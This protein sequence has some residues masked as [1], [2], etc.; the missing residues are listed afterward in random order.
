MEN[1]ALKYR[2]TDFEALVG[3]ETTVQA[4]NAY[5]DLS[6][7]KGHLLHQV[8]LF[9]GERGTGKTTSARILSKALNCSLGPTSHPCGVCPSCKSPILDIIEWNAANTSSIND[10]RNLKQH[11]K[12][13]PA[14]GKY[15][16]YILDEI[17]MFSAQAFDA[18]LKLL[19]EPPKHAVFILATTEL[20]DIPETIRSRVQI[21]KFNL[22]PEEKI[23][24]NLEKICKQEGVVMDLESLAYIARAGKG[25]M[26]DSITILSRILF[27]GEGHANLQEVLT[28]LG[29]TSQ[30]QIDQLLSFVLKKDPRMLEIL[31]ELENLGVDWFLFWDDLIKT[32]RSH[33]EQHFEIE[34]V[35]VYA[36]ILRT[37]VYRRYDL[38]LVNNPRVVVELTLLTI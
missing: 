12:S 6:G 1:L 16:V 20:Q 10:V 38:S 3:Q 26:R 15:R 8:F 28:H 22:I 23:V 30:A 13:S 19:E 34:D 11:V 4:L 7:K 31:R 5:L 9:A 17:H 25:S 35:S 29:Y 37:L 18:L 24:K 2:P 32:L 14:F 21:Y 27:S 36:K 33:I